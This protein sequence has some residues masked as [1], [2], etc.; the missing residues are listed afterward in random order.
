MGG[1]GTGSNNYYLMSIKM[2]R[3]GSEWTKFASTFSQL[4]G[5]LFTEKY[6]FKFYPNYKEIHKITL[7]KKDAATSVRLIVITDEETYR[8]LCYPLNSSFKK[9]TYIQLKF[10]SLQ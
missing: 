9:E 2:G 6:V 3:V 1:L 4:H 8:R 10:I 5:T 7:M